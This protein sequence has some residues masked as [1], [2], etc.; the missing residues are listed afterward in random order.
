MSSNYDYAYQLCLHL[1]LTLSIRFPSATDLLP[2]QSVCNSDDR[3]GATSS[4]DLI[5]VPSCGHVTPPTPTIGIKILRSLIYCSSSWREQRTFPVPLSARAPVSALRPEPNSLYITCTES[6]SIRVC[7]RHL[8][9]YAQALGRALVQ[10]LG[11]AP[12]RALGRAQPMS[13]LALCYALHRV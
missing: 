5:V 7:R 3:A 11:R 4:T 8:L 2:M 9:P 10:V 1:F 12:V 6:V 13:L